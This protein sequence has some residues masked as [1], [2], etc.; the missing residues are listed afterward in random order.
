[1]RALLVSCF[2]L[3]LFACENRETAHT[4]AVSAGPE[5][6]PAR[7]FHPAPES[8]AP[9]LKV[10]VDWRH[11]KKVPLGKTTT[12]AAN[13]NVQSLGPVEEVAAGAPEIR[14]PGMGAWAAPK[15]IPVQFRIVPA[16][17]PEE[18]QAKDMAV[19]DHNPASF[20]Y[21][22]KLQGL[23]VK[24]IRC[25]AEDKFRNLWIGTEFGGATRYDGRFFWHYGREE[26]LA[27]EMIHSI[28]ADSKG[29]LW[30]G[31]DNGLSR[32]DG[33]NF[34]NLTAE[35]GLSGNE[36][37]AFCED[38]KG[39]MWIG[40]DGGLS[41]L[42]GQHLITY[43]TAE[44]LPDNIIN[45]LL[46]DRQG[47]LWMGTEKNDEFESG[48]HI[49]CLEGLQLMVYGEQQ[50]WKGYPVLCLAEDR[51][52]QIYVGSN[53]GGLVIFNQQ[54]F[55]YINE[56]SGLIG[57]EIRSILTE[58]NGLVW[59][60]TE[61]G[62]FN[63][64]NNR[65]TRFG[66]NEGLCEN[67]IKRIF[68]DA[69]GNLWI[70]TENGLAKYLGNA[71]Q[72]YTKQEGLVNSSISSIF[73]DTTGCFWIGGDY[74]GISR[75]NGSNFLNTSEE[76]GLP[77]SAISSMFQNSKRKIYI[78]T[79][80]G[81]VE[82][83]KSNQ[84]V[85]NEQSGLSSSL[86]SAIA[87]DKK[88]N[89]WL[90]GTAGICIFDGFE[91]VK[92]DKSQGLS[93][94]NITSIF[95][96]SRGFVWI[97]TNGGGIT[98]YNNGQFTHF[99][100]ENGFPNDVVLSICEDHQ[101][102]IWFGSMDGL[103]GYNGKSFTHFTT[104]QG[105]SNNAVFS[106][107]PD[108]KGN[109][110][111]GTRAGINLLQA[112]ALRQINQYLVRKQPWPEDFR[113]FR[114]FQYD[115]GFL[116]MGC[117]K[118]SIVEARDGKI[119]V[120]ANDRLTIIN[121]AALPVDGLP[122]SIQL[123]GIDLFGKR[124]QANS[125]DSSSKGN[126]RFDSLSPWYRL[127]MNLNLSHN[128]NSLTFHFIGITTSRPGRICY[129]H[130]LEGWE[131]RWTNESPNPE[132]SYSNLPPGDYCFVVQARN[133]EG[134]WSP[135][136]R[137]NFTIRYPWWRSW[138]AYGFYF[139]FT[140]ASF[141]G[142][143]RQRE[144]SL[145]QRQR[146]LESGIRSATREIREKQ[147]ETEQQRALI[148]EQKELTEQQKSI[149]EEKHRE[150]MDSIAYARRIQNAILP[151]ARSMK[152][153]LPESF[154]LYLPKDIVA[155]D[156]YWMS[157]IPESEKTLFASCDCTG[158]GVPGAMVS[159]VCSNALNKAVN[160]FGLIEPAAILNKVAE[161]VIRDLQRGEVEGD[162]E[163]VKDGMDIS[164]CLFDAATLQLQWA[165]ANN[166]LWIVRS[167]NGEY[168]L[169]ELK[170]DKMAIGNTL[171]EAAFF[172]HSIQL[173][174]GDC[175]YL[176]SDGYS[177]QFGGE[178]GKKLTKKGFRE[179][180]LTAPQKSMEQQRAFLLEAHQQWRKNEQQVDDICV[181]GVRV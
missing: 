43:T 11:V 169:L 180:L 174:K 32:F 116:G 139:L 18:V 67:V 79:F 140:I 164:L 27:G 46:L 33:Q 45:S 178:R 179:L 171:P 138:W 129:H 12:I 69:A 14:I 121:P 120:G 159:V 105:L 48:G 92:L 113:P 123:R 29:N 89:L 167:I 2:C 90:G 143:I 16:G 122:P 8:L 154:V 85:Y 70:G 86:V 175:L 173:E 99:R 73:E 38:R 83:S 118:N 156:F 152:R 170:A 71:F 15:K 40:T 41:C 13:Q 177:D 58:P 148:Q 125:L 53:G 162:A 124:I 6:I 119:W 35:T 44:G 97:G 5:I 115:D 111:I 77:S 72:H 131:D 127:P 68:K 93:E 1:M 26:G 82:F 87:E 136:Y 54:Q 126:V 19:K 66:E 155:G 117:N 112:S 145:R 3:L 150:V 62:L 20:S 61:D 84:I 104:N 74:G 128:S 106:L 63:M 153:H 50:G 52:G 107:L 149:I 10:P 137:Y 172:N 34:Y 134:L 17:Q 103:I 23:K 64:N 36:V 47:R 7:P 81:L 94:S 76:F 165:G 163:F 21:F 98:R 59:F 88:G 130:R 51:S 142:Y 25:M 161:L 49:A 147:E 31:T 166:P 168:N 96:D 91:F 132:A 57:S 114:S 146:E 78:G 95:S 56:K 80:G 75:F 60:G 37:F 160:E 42:D 101:G 110:W 24:F 133:S 144:K 158:H 65:I 100:Q 9:P 30:F 141:G 157:P 4:K 55:R 135:E 39:R 28:Y 108:R 151:S 109:L 22:S 181:I 102:M 176:F